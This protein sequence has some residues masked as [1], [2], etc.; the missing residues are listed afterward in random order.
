MALADPQV[1]PGTPTIDLD[2]ISAALGAFASAD[3]VKELRVDHSNGNRRR[4]VVKLT[5]R[6]IASD[7]LLP[8]QNREYQQSVHLV[9]DSPKSGFS[10]AEV[11]AAVEQFVNYLDDASLLADVIQGQA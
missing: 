10:N 3:S 7:P 2:R 4:S 6:K 11:L 9:I 5:T 8:A 1:L